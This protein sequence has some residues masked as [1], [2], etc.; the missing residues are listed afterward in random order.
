[1]KYLLILLYSLLP[2]I[3]MAQEINLDDALDELSSPLS[4]DRTV[5]RQQLIYYEGKGLGW[6]M[7]ARWKDDVWNEQLELLDIVEARKDPALREQALEWWRGENHKHCV[8]YLLS[9]SEDDLEASD[10]KHIEDVLSFQALYK[11]VVFSASF[12]YVH[13]GISKEHYTMLRHDSSRVNKTAIA[14]LHLKES[15]LEPIHMA[16]DHII[17]HIKVLHLSMELRAPLEDARKLIR[18]EKFERPRYYRYGIQ[19]LRHLQRNALTAL[20]SSNTPAFNK[21]LHKLLVFY[22]QK[23]PSSYKSVYE[24]RHTKFQSEFRATLYLLGDKALYEAEIRVEASRLA[25]FRASLIAIKKPLHM[26]YAY[27]SSV[28]YM[29]RYYAL[30]GEHDQ[31]VVYFK[32]AINLANM[33]MRQFLFGIRPIMSRGLLREAYYNMACSYALQTNTTKALTAL[34]KAVAIGKFD[35]NWFMV[36]PDFDSIITTP[37]FQDWLDKYAPPSALD[38]QKAYRDE[39]ISKAREKAKEDPR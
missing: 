2:S 4:A 9:L 33:S 37:D 12:R 32:E 19:F 18:Y 23:Y 34:K 30:I 5:A 16:R 15:T 8:E 22:T 10:S 20:Q 6:R 36:D 26:D 39:R 3:M 17:R 14:L 24:L 31:A 38:K 13:G 7:R 35:W 25:N 29:G 28:I 1:M 11:F 27:I 21:E